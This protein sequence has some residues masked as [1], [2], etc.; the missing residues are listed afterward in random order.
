MALYY[1]IGFANNVS[2]TTDKTP[3]SKWFDGTDL[4]T[5]KNFGDDDYTKQ[6]QAVRII[7]S[8]LKIS[9]KQFAQ[10]LIDLY[11]GM[12][13]KKL[14]QVECNMEMAHYIYVIDRVLPRKCKDYTKYINYIIDMK[15]TLCDIVLDRYKIYSMQGIITS[16]YIIDRVRAYRTC[17]GNESFAFEALYFFETRN[18]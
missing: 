1:R 14:S 10:Y 4:Y 17:I 11:L 16:H 5:L 18:I 7:T 13:S 9:S 2:I 6:K 8:K 12:I 15:K 3:S